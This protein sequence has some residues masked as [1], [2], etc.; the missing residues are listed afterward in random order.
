MPSDFGE[1][2]PKEPFLKD[3][4]ARHF[5]VTRQNAQRLIL[6]G[7]L[8]LLTRERQGSP[9]LSTLKREIISPHHVTRKGRK[10]K[11]FT[12]DSKEDLYLSE[13]EYDCVVASVIQ[14][15]NPGK[16]TP[17]STLL[18][19]YRNGFKF[20]FDAYWG[21]FYPLHLSQKGNTMPSPFPFQISHEEG[22]IDEVSPMAYMECS[23]TGT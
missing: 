15:G 2:K 13:K 19:Q 20:W 1:Q 12:C 11:V 5:V 16:C 23:D 4:T 8:M 10:D 14:P 9:D 3:S 21:G 7:P 17:M 18:G 22:G 6:K